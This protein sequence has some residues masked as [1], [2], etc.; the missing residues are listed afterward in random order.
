M[1]FLQVFQFLFRKWKTSRAPSIRFV[2]IC[3]WIK[4][5][6]NDQDILLNLLMFSIGSFARL[7]EKN[8]S[9]SSYVEVLS[10]NTSE[11]LYEASEAAL[12]ER[13]LHVT[14]CEVQ[15]CTLSF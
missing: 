1:F 3:K 2:H 15:N 8:A 6:F 13:S 14:V 4:R 7:K 9:S 11:A 10:N 12:M 5:L